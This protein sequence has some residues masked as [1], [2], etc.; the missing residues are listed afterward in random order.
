L[1]GSVNFTRNKHVKIKLLAPFL[2][3]SM[4]MAYFG[5]ALKLP[6]IIFFI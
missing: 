3:T 2:I 4:P 5:G 1:V 6:K